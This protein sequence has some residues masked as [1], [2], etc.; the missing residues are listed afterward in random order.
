ME[1]SYQLHA[2]APLLPG[3]DPSEYPLDKRLGGLQDLSGCCGVKKYLLTLLGIEP[4]P[5]S[6]RPAAIPTEL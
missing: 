5:S 3:K 4:R 2:S 1:V 6:P